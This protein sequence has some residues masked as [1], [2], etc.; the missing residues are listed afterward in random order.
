MS[1]DSTLDRRLATPLLWVCGGL[2]LI[3]QMSGC[4]SR[5][6]TDYSSLDLAEVSGMMTLD[7]IPLY[8]ATVQFVAADGTYSAGLTNERG[9]YTLMFNSEKAGVLTGPKTV[10]IVT[11][12]SEGDGESDEVPAH[13]SGSAEFV[14]DCYNRDS[15]LTADVVP[16]SQTFDFDLTSDCGETQTDGDG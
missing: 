13:S 10:R 16:G 11:G 7:G 6:R 1:S 4:E 14:P 2:G 15:R 12:S 3:M 8:G 5:I 9:E